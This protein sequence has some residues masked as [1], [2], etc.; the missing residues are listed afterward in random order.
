MIMNSGLALPNNDFDAIILSS[1]DHDQLEGLSADT[2]IYEE[3]DFNRFLQT[4][5]ED[6]LEHATQYVKQRLKGTKRWEN[7]VAFEKLA[8]RLAYELTERFIA[9]ARTNLPMR[10]VLLLEAFITQ[11]L[12]RVDLLSQEQSIL[13][14]PLGQYLDTIIS[15]AV[16]S[17]DAL[18]TL[19]WHIYSMTPSHVMKVLAIPEDQQARIFK[20]YARWRKAGWEQAMMVS[21]LSEQRLIDLEKEVDQDW[22]GI[23]KK[24]SHILDRIQP[25][26]RKSEPTHYPC[27][28]KEAWLDLYANGY[29]QDYRVWHLAMCQHCFK[30]L[31]EIQMTGLSDEWQPLTHFQVRPYGNEIAT[32]KKSS[33]H[34]SSL[35][36]HL[37]EP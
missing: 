37:K 16:V 3:E 33:V 18:V 12:S 14:S 31:C 15:R 36:D 35:F 8:L 5:S 1:N 4:S 11:S 24:V 10:P 22:R 34:R 23:N 9:D 28:D 2:I 30:S 27:R 19:F 25:Y 17:R 26:Y 29:D 6:L 21:G 20:N 13:S 7:T 32:D